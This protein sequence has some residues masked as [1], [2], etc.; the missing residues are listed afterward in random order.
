MTARFGREPT[1]GAF[2]YGLVVICALAAA[3]FLALPGGASVGQVML[4]LGLPFWVNALFARRHVQLFDANGGTAV[5]II[6]TC[7]TALTLLALFSATYTDYPM[8]VGRTV[9][10]ML[11]AVAMFT[12]LAGTLTRARIAPLIATLGGALAFVSLMST[13]AYFLPDLRE[14]F[15]LQ[16]D[17]SSGTFKNPNQ[18]GIAISTVL[19]VTLGLFLASKGMLRLFCLACIIAMVMGLFVSGSKANLL[20][21][22]LSM[23]MF[24]LIMGAISFRG[25]ERT[26]VIF[27]LLIGLALTLIAAIAVLQILNP[28][29]LFLINVFFD[30]NQSV[31]SLVSRRFIWDLSIEAFMLNPWLGEGAGQ[32]IRI[33]PDGEVISHSHNIFLDA[34]RTLGAAGLVFMSLVI[35]TVVTMLVTT[36][37]GLLSRDFGRPRTQALLLGAAVSSGNYVLANMSSES[38]GPST[39][40]FFWLVL[41]LF[42]MLRGEILR[43]HRMPTLKPLLLLFGKHASRT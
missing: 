39:S 16:T 20:L 5:T 11:A 8:R 28:R 1:Q 41:F 4:L 29:A 23:T 17:R 37:L 22:G 7:V 27:S 38:F 34:A 15:F 19:P 35:V 14:F 10:T 31:P 2:L 21:L 26:F 36:V 3:D 9:T 13:A 40:P 24:A 6:L 32:Q 42:F 33:K 18:Y 25:V 12:F 30:P 43:S